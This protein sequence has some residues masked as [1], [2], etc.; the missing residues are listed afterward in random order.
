M[1]SSRNC[2]AWLRKTSTRCVKPTASSL[3][4]RWWIRVRA[5]SNPS[6]RTSTA[7]MKWNRN[8]SRA[9]A[10]KSSSWAPVRSVSGQ[11][12][13]FD[14]ATV[15]AVWAIQETS[16]L[17]SDRPSTTTRKPFR[18]I[19]R[20]PTSWYF[21]PLTEE[22][23]MAIIDLEQPLGVVVQFGGQ[24]AIWPTN[25]SYGVKILGTSLEDLDRAEDR[26]LFEQLLR[27]LDIPRPR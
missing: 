17:R 15:H 8:H 9:T 2:G 16:A 25:W 24:T 13:E 18:R 6:H 22:D 10:K 21:E 7:R 5:N 20:S 23:V 26:K 3:S 11:G 19:S 12:V 14:Y 27:D 1:K 4:S